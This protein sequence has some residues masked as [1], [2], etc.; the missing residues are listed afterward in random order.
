MLAGIEE[1]RMLRKRGV[2]VRIFPGALTPYVRYLKLFLKKNSNSIILHIGTNNS[3]NET[4]RNILNGILSL[5]NFIEKFCPA[6]KVIVSYVVYR[7]DNGEAYLTVKNVNDHLDALNIDVVDN[8]HISRNCLKNSGLHL[9]STVYGKLVM[10]FMT[11]MKVL[12]K[13]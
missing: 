8:I 3:V 5:K 1:K 4:S 6:C 12:S 13:N 11:K 2:K 10:N 7:S 9:N